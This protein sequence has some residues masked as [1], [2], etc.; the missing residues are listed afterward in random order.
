MKAAHQIALESASRGLVSGTLEE[1][2]VLAAA[3]RAAGHPLPPTATAREMR[4][5]ALH[6]LGEDA[7][8]GTRDRGCCAHCAQV[9][10]LV[11]DSRESRAILERVEKQMVTRH[12]FNPVRA[13]AY[14]LVLLMATVFIGAL[15]NAALK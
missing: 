1:W 12:E 10:E 11:G 4:D 3:L 7:P 14:G 15:A 5:A 9:S 6:A 13:V 8:S 2:P